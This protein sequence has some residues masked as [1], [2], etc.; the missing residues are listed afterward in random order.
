MHIGCIQ[1]MHLIFRLPSWKRFQQYVTLERLTCV[2]SFVWVPTTSF[3]T[4][5][6]HAAG[7]WFN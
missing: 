7:W 4:R 6:V 1:E 3:R 2:Y 5:E